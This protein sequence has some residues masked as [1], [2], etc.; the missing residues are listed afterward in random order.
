MVLGFKELIL[1]FGVWGTNIV[2][3]LSS[4]WVLTF[5]ELVREAIN[6]IAAKAILDTIILWVLKII[7]TKSM[8]E[9]KLYWYMKKN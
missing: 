1:G 9:S 8:A 7:T 6:F 2:Q 5:G 4:Q 3:F